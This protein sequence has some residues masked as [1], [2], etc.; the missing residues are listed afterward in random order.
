VADKDVITD[1]TH[2]NGVWTQEPNF[3]KWIDRDT[4]LTCVIIRHPQLGHLCGYV[5]V[6]HGSF[7]KRLVA[8]NRIPGRVFL[9]KMRCHCATHHSSLQGITVHGG[10]TWANSRLRDGRL[11]P[12]RGFWLGF[13]CAHYADLSPNMSSAFAMPGSVYRDFPYVEQECVS[14]AKQVKVLL[15]GRKIEERNV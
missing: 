1:M 15:A 2:Q 12:M 4:G 6:P 3:K 14:L 7:K 10:V 5:R 9:G 13:D 8:Y 11:L